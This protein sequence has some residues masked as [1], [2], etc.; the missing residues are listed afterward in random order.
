M[1]QHEIDAENL[2]YHPEKLPK[3]DYVSVNDY[4]S[5]DIRA[6]RIIDVE[7]YPEM[8]KPSYKIIVDFGPL[9]GELSSS[10]Q[11]TNSSRSELINR[12]VVGSINLGE[13]TLPGGFISQFL[14]LGALDPDG[15]VNL[16]EL[17][18]NILLGSIVA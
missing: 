5:L 4:F 6:G 18:S 11:I 7:N 13:K 2:P 3:K 17:P 15:T 12:L 16:L 1:G 9:I 8:R 10:A 14:V